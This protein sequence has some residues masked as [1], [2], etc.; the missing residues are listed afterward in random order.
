MSKLQAFT[1]I[2]SNLIFWTFP[3]GS[4]STPLTKNPNWHVMFFFPIVT[5]SVPAVEVQKLTDALVGKS[6]QFTGR[7][8]QK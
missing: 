7:D 8:A 3:K 5:K 2:Y 4:L 6:S 1:S